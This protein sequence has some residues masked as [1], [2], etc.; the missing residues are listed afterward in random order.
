[1]EPRANPLDRVPAT[2]LVITAIFSVQFGNA[3]VGSLF[4]RV[5]PFGAA[6]LRLGCGALILA[7]LVRPRVAGWSRRTWLGALLLGLGLGGMNL[8]IYLAIDR[9]PLGVA[10]TIELMGPLAVAAAGSRRPVD[11]AWVLLAA[12]GIA[13]LGVHA[14][15]AIDIV[16]ALLA[17]TAAA[18][19]ALYILASARL[20]A[21]VHGVDGLSAAMVV[22]AVV[23]VPVGLFQAAP[24]VS[25][26][27]ALLAAFAGVAVLTSVIPYALEFTAL[28]RISTRV[29][30]VL[31]SLGP[32]VAAFAGFVVLGQ[33]LD[34]RQ[35]GAIAL[36]VAASAGVVA[37]SRRR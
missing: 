11:G 29:F 37:T 36:V 31:S 24:A 34:A 15:G 25:G 10:V 3:I 32:A 18:C 23:I 17:A 20:G 26:D 4:D 21:R 13:L 28:K 19:W 2:A 30:G 9:I 1:M 5:G 14:G 16:G 33:S 7:L 12:T 35:L 22:A 27:P 8:F 6:A